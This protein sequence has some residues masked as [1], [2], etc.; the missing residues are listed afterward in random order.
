MFSNSL[1]PEADGFEVL[2]LAEL[3]KYDLQEIQSGVGFEDYVNFAA[4]TFGVP[5]AVLSFVGAETQYFKAKTGTT[6]PQTLR[7]VSFCMQAIQQPDCLEVLD[8][9]A[10]DRLRENLLVT[11]P[12]FIRF[13]AAAPLV[14]PAGHT[15]GSICILDTAPHARFSPKDRQSLAELSRMI[16]CKLEQF[17][18]TDVEKHA[19]PTKENLPDSNTQFEL[20]V[21]SV[22]NYALYTLTPSGHVASWNDGA[23]RIE[24]YQ[25]EEIVGR[26]FSELYTQKERDEGLPARALNTS[27]E[28]GTYHAE[29]LRVRKNGKTFW[30]SEVIDPIFDGHKEL[31]GYSKIVRDIS[32]KR[33]AY[34]R[35]VELARTDLLTGLPNGLAIKE[36]ADRVL[37]TG[38][39][40]IAFRVKVRGLMDFHDHLGPSDSDNV[41]RQVA[42]RIREAAPSTA[43]VGCIGGNNFAMAIPDTSDPEDAS[44]LCQRLIGEFARPFEWDGQRLH[45]ELLIGVSLSPMHGVKAEEL[46]ATASIALVEAGKLTGG[47]WCMFEPQMRQAIVKRRSIEQALQLAVERSELELYFQ[48][49]VRLTD[50]KIIG[51]EA[52]LR[53]RHPEQGLMAPR[54]F[55]PILEN[56]MLAQTVGTN[57]IF[58]ACRH[59]AEAR[60][61]SAENYFVA[62]NLFGSELQSNTLVKIVQDALKRYRLPPDALQLEVTENVILEPS[63][64][65]IEQFKTLRTSG[66]CI[67][68]DDY[69]TGYASLSVLKN[70]P[71]DR[72]KIDLSFVRGMCTDV[73]DAAVVKAILY[74]AKNFGLSVTAEGIEN[75]EQESL[76]KQLGCGCGQGFLYGRALQSNEILHLLIGNAGPV[77]QHSV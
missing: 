58:T 16:T 6:M 62:V 47:G 24:G 35:L 34:E 3:A 9:S 63:D 22:T 29:V 5:M 8:A 59:A 10:D 25:S 73:E 56:S 66:I 11:G 30:A 49:Q 41:L 33:A 36:Q 15:I 44:N 20:L 74:L 28:K 65:I 75:I 19:R 27:M 68:L 70:F 52:L 31:I 39:D 12:P 17:R 51:S 42:N 57:I 71:V 43:L 32:E 38:Q 13:Y 64:L 37:A 2:R 4:R 60:A 50:R 77:G 55:L 54:E 46:A 26:H 48:P 23:L 76:L 72:L 40:M 61:R 53:W 14:A 21:N 69:G 1:P 7:M 67:A 18:L 45:L